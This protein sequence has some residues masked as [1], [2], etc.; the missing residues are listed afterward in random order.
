M[1]Q[2]L[3]GGFFSQKRNAQCDSLTFLESLSAQP[4]L[5]A[6]SMPALAGEQVLEFKLVTTPVDV[7]VFEAANLDGQSLSA[8]KY[9][10]VAYFKDG[11]IAVKNFVSSGEVLKGSA[12]FAASA[13]TPSTMALRLLRVTWDE[14][15]RALLAPV[16]T[17]SCP[18]PVPSPTRP[19]PVP[20]MASR[21]HL[22]APFFSTAL[23]RESALKAS[24][25]LAV[26]A[27]R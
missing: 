23:R 25:Q 13:R 26:A 10:G 3:H 27:R 9:F 16:L 4:V 19:A 24:R 8:G 21:R 7:K 22:R 12:P 14:P 15:Y 17:R 11:R 6:A 20:S 2:A 18:A 1:G 5:F